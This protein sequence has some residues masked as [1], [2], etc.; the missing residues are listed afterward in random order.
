MLNNDITH[1]KIVEADREP[2]HGATKKKYESDNKYIGAQKSQ[3][4]TRLG[5]GS[6][7]NREEVVPN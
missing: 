5:V 7:R 1:A 4:M 3:H 2:P 6:H